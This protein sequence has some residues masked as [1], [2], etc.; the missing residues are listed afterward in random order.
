[1]SD[2]PRTV[3]VA[4]M[5]Y[6]PDYTTVW[7]GQPPSPGDVGEWLRKHREGWSVRTL[8]RATTVSEVTAWCRKQGLKRLDWD[9]VPKQKIWFREPEV[10]MLWDLTC[11]KNT[12]ENS[13]DESPK[14]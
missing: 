12:T 10:A 5:L 13:V 14:S 1:M 2:R 9:F 6:G 8:D 11:S 3:Q 4:E 7:T